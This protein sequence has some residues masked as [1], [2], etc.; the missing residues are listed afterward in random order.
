MF[1][2]LC[3]SLPQVVLS[4]L[5]DGATGVI[6]VWHCTKQQR[7]QQ[8]T[9]GHNKE[10]NYDKLEVQD[11]VEKGQNPSETGSTLDAHSSAPVRP[12]LNWST[13]VAVSVQQ[14]QTLFPTPS[15]QGCEEAANNQKPETDIPRMHTQTAT[16][17][18][19]VNDTD[20]CMAK[21]CKFSAVEQ[22][23]NVELV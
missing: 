17:W 5:Q 1:R 20:L 10:A 11:V 6:C 3:W 2:K 15:S 16:M 19:N 18:N 8:G 7:R 14:L 12:I 4:L 22:L 9:H 23:A 13:N 21:S